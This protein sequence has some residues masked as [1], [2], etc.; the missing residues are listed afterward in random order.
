MLNTLGEFR[1]RKDEL[2]PAYQSVRLGTTSNP[3]D[4]T[5]FTAVQA[6]PREEVNLG[7]MPSLVSGYSSI[8]IDLNPFDIA[9]RADSKE[10]YFVDLATLTV[11]IGW[12]A[13][14]GGSSEALRTGWKTLLFL[15][16]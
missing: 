3:F 16:N 9:Y 13:A 8:G 1:S 12:A 15:L 14:T 6:L 10:E 11:K 2:V 4:V 5:S 7:G